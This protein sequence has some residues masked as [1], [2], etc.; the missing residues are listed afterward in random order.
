MQP[1][2]D[3]AVVDQ[4]MLD[5]SAEFSSKAAEFK[6]H[7]SSVANE[8][9][10]IKQYWEGDSATIFQNKMLEWQES[11]A[12]VVGALEDIQRTMDETIAGYNKGEQASTDV[13][14]AIQVDSAGSQ[15]LG[16]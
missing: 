5:A 9:A 14:G 13:V 10:E 8:L 3:L 16:F 7:N 4:G 11:F 15:G 12:R 1:S 2:G 6:G